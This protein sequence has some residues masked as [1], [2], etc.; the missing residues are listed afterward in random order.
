MGLQHTF[1]MFGATVLVPILT[2]LDVGVTLFAAGVGT[3]IFHIMTGFKVP[4][5]LGSSFA[6]IPGLM[7]IGASQGLPYALGG[8]VVA[9][10]LYVIVG[11]IFK[12]VSYENLHKILPAHVTGPM[13]ILIGMILAPV[14]ISSAN[15]TNSPAI[16]ESIGVNGCWGVALFT[17]AV[18]VFVK[19]AFPKF[20]WKFL[21]NL[22]VLIAL[23]AG[24]LFSV[25]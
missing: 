19:I 8:I 15:G 14:A 25:I 16:A 17:F 20:G 23:V 22:P 5:F 4:V 1:V 3:W 18:G 21:S 12:F 2:G 11:A 7:A 10:L 13:I 24:Y 9:G 6:F